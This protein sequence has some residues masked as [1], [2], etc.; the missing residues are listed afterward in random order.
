MPTLNT[1]STESPIFF[2]VMKTI[3]LL[4][5]I[6]VETMSKTNTY[7][8]RALNAF[9]PFWLKFFPFLVMSTFKYTT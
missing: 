9:V 2:P 3:Y 1:Q 6:L 5:N 7:N 4:K 8:T